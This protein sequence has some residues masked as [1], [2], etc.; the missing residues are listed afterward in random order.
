MPRSSGVQGVRGVQE[1]N[2][3]ACRRWLGEA[4]VKTSSFAKTCPFD[5]RQICY[6]SKPAEPIPGRWNSIP[7]ARYIPRLGALF[8]PNHHGYEVL[9]TP[10]VR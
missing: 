5:N 8:G 10:R 1:G 3:R 2:E 7:V 4:P 9:K 6:A